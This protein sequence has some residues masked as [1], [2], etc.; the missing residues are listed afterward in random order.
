M[1]KSERSQ[2]RSESRS[3]ALTLNSDKEEIAPMLRTPHTLSDVNMPQYDNQRRGYMTQTD[4]SHLPDSSYDRN[5][6]ALGSSQMPA[7]SPYI[8]STQ[9]ENETNFDPK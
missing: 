9:D 6:N 3:S 2:S 7:Q 1:T 8:L 4:P 5:K